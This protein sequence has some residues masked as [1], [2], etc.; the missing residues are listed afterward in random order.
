MQICVLNGS[1]KNE[2]S[3]VTM[4]Y[5]MFLQKRLPHIQFKIINIGAC[6]SKIEKSEREFEEILKA[7]EVSD[8]VIWGFPLYFLLVAS[9]FKRFIE[10]VFEK[11]KTSFFM[12]KPAAILATSIH[13]CDNYAINY[14]REVSEDLGM[15]YYDAYSAEMND[16]IKEK[17][18]VLFTNFTLNYIDFIESK[19][20]NLRLSLPLVMD[21][22]KLELNQNK[23]K[24]VKTNKKVLILTDES[25]IEQNLKQM[26]TYLQ[27]M[28]GNQAEKVHLDEFQMKGGCLG[29]VKCG[30]DFT[31]VYDGNDNYRR[32]FEEKV[33]KA[34]IIFFCGAIQDR[35]LS[36]KWKRFFDRSFFHNHSSLIS[37][38]QTAMIISGPFRQMSNLQNLFINYFEVNNAQLAGFV[39]DDMG[40]NLQIEKAIQNLAEKVVC[41]ADDRYLAPKTFLGVAGKKI[42]RDDIYSK[43]RFPF[44]ADFKHYK[45]SGSF[46]FPQ[47]HYSILTINRILSF[48]A[49]FPKIRKELYN[50]GMEIGLYQPFRKIINQ[51]EAMNE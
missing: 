5:I 44:I 14:V 38:K 48:L 31:C 8:G 6:I 33:V 41:N 1:P 7:V 22:P 21:Q 29:C 15:N 40:N 25:D 16:L 49:I 47:K 37:G 12:N 17:E 11:E 50:K 2:K 4:H 51:T 18:R 36:S 39:S 27:T 35:Y 42:F 46:D 19:K 13:F 28:F 30:Y 23:N 45:K 32:L 10:L 26:T 20:T 43:L 9:Q 34:D 3:S 24:K